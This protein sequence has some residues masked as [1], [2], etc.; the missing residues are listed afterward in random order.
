[1]TDAEAEN[2]RWSPD[3]RRQIKSEMNGLMRE[4]NDVLRRRS[5]SGRWLPPSETDEL[6]DNA[7]LARAGQHVLDKLEE[8]ISQAR[9]LLEQV[10]KDAKR[11]SGISAPS[12]KPQ[13][14]M[15][16]QEIVWAMDDLVFAVTRMMQLYTSP[17]GKWA[18]AGG[19]SRSNP[20][21][22][23]VWAARTFV[24]EQLA[25]HLGDAEDA[26]NL[27]DRRDGSAP[28]PPDAA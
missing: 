15:A 12:G 28:E 6:G 27:W 18:P 21:D 25:E 1:M 5:D 3:V 13:P 20:R 26:V 11:R 8:R 14:H 19:V 4:L 7:S 10:E 23:L 24:L 22:D 9:R 16:T 2:P 17:D